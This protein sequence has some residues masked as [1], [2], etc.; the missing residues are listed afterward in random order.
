MGVLEYRVARSCYG[1]VNDC[2][3]VELEGESKR[4][5]NG[6]GE[7]AHGAHGQC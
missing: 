3:E 4:G 1:I 7:C 2:I 6:R 5:E